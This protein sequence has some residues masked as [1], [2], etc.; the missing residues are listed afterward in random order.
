MYRGWSHHHRLTLPTHQHDHLN[1]REAG[2]SHFGPTELQ[3]RTSLR[4]VL[5]VTDVQNY[6]VGPQP[7]GPF[8]CL[9]HQTTNKHPRQGSPPSKCL[10][11]W[12]YGEKLAKE[13]F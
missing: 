2:P 4:V 5:Q 13:A 7:G 3:S 6:R 9:M 1:N 8:M 10:Y 12:S 11:R